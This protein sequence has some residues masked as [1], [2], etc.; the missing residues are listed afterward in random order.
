MDE[1][2]NKR[3]AEDDVDLSD[4][5]NKYQLD[6][7]PRPTAPTRTQRPVRETRQ[8]PRKQEGRGVR[9]A[10]SVL[11]WKGDSVFEMLR[12]VLLLLSVLVLIAC[13]C[14]GV[15]RF[16]QRADVNK[17]NGKYAALVDKSLNMTLDEAKQ[18]YPDVDFPEGMQTKFYGLYGLNQDFVGWLKIDGKNIDFPIV[19]AEDNDFYLRRDF[20]KVDTDYGNA[21]LD[22]RNAVKAPLDRNT[23]IYGHYMRDNM[24]FAR[25]KDYLSLDGF[26]ASPVIDFDMLFQNTK[27]KIYA[28]MVTNAE[29]KSDNGYVFDYLHPTFPSDAKFAEYMKEIDQRKLYTTGVD[30]QPTDKIITLSTCYTTFS[31]ARLVVI[32]RLVRD[33]EDPAVDTAKAY[34]NEN[35]RYPQAWYDAKGK[36]N[37]YK[38]AGKWI[39]N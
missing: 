23:I 16:M 6:K 15:N 19:Q 12:K 24:I 13:A 30:I 3:H 32:G 36:P 34:Y 22:Y 29:A 8:T 26:K 31:D 35:P 14:W 20:E 21:F 5:R 33:G 4:L 39:I 28:V 7:E 38:D 25:L 18:Q 1:N 17:N 11:P 2:K 10:K 9:M 27:W 37:P